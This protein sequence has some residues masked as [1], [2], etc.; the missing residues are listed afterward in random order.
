[1]LR[2]GCCYSAVLLLLLA[3]LPMHA[4]CDKNTVNGRYG[5][6]SSQRTVLKPGSAAIKV[7]FIGLVNYDGNGVVTGAGLL[8]GP[9]GNPEP[10]SVKGTYA[11]AAACTGQVMLADQKNSQ[12]N[13]RFVIVN[14][15]NELL[16]ISEKSSDTTPFSQK[17]Q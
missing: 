8:V 2:L 6:V 5:F 3:A 9:S 17:K 16:T 13:W 10:I 4:Q 15:A 11:V 12:T 7:R 1:M 14:G